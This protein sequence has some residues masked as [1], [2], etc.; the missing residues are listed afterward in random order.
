[1][2][3]HVITH[4]GC[5]ETVREC[6][7]EAV[8]GRKIACRS[9]TRTCVSVACGFSIGRCT[10]WT[11]TAPCRGL[12]LWRPNMSI[13]DVLNS[14]ELLQTWK[15]HWAVGMGTQRKLH[16]QHE[17]NFD[18]ASQSCT[19][20]GTLELIRRRASPQLG[21]A[22]V[23]IKVISSSLLRAQNWQIISLSKAGVGQNIAT[24]ASPSATNSFRVLFYTFPVCSPSFSQI[25]SS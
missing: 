4:G 25:I 5:T 19:L 3:L 16:V 10:S 1:M 12:L 9:G 6:A 15:C 11:V 20:Q 21:T 18:S 14:I 24:H 2:L 22:D 17:I 7:L 23:E 13:Y 8:S